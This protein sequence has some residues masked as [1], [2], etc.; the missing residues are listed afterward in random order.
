MPCCLVAA[1]QANHHRIVDSEDLGLGKETAHSL[2]LSVNATRVNAT[3]RAIPSELWDLGYK[4]ATV[5]TPI[6]IHEG[7]QQEAKR[8]GLDHTTWEY[9]DVYNKFPVDLSRD[10]DFD[11]AGLIEK[12]EQNFREKGLE[13]KATVDATRHLNKLF[14]EV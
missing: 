7:L 9:M 5:C 1:T 8:L 14:V 6:Q 10:N 3:G 2:D 4:L 11:A 12:L 13:Y